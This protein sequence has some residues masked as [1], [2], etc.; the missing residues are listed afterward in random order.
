MR[1][2]VWHWRTLQM[3]EAGMASSSFIGGKSASD[4]SWLSGVL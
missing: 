3:S 4:G 1:S 2:W